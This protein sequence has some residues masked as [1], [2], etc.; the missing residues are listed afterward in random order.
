M[1]IE[2]QILLAI[3]DAS[4]PALDLLFRI[5]HELGGY[6]F[7]TLLVI[8]AAVFYRR[9]DDRREQRLWLGLGLST[10]VLQAGLKRLIARP[11]P[12][13]WSEALLSAQHT[14]YA[15]PS[16]H[17]LAAATFYPLLAHALA[18]AY[19]RHV[20]L[21]RVAAVAMAFYVGFGRLY[22]GVHWPSD[23]LVGW[24]LGATQT[25]LALRL[26]AHQA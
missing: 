18:R 26:R 15:M 7:C 24:T 3:H 17:A 21:F 11:R 14:S 12:E 23:V 22:L 25:W 1:P 13:L 20:Q 9:P 2:Q 10:L 16:G 5:S 19:P 8:G 4:T 6:W